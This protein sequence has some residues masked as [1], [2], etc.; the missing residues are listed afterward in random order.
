MQ[1]KRFRAVEFVNREKDIRYFLDY[2][3]NDP[4]RILWVYGF[5]SAGK[6]TLIEYV[7]EQELIRNP[8][9]FKKS[10]YWIKYINF[11]G[12]FVT[13]YDNFLYSF[14][15]EVDE[16]DDFTDRGEVDVEFNLGLIRINSRLFKQIKEKKT[17]LFD[18]LIQ[19]LK[20]IKKKKIII[21]D[22]IQSLQD[23]YLNG[24]RLLLNE[25]LNFCV[26]LT[27]ELHLSH[28]VI[29]TSNTIFLREIYNNSRLKKTSE[30]KLIGDLSQEDI[31]DW[32]TIKGFRKS[33]IDLI[34]EYIGGRAGDVKKLLD[35]V[36]YYNCIED[37]LEEE[38]LKAKSEIKIFFEQSKLSDEAKEKF[39]YVIGEIV[40]AGFF[41]NDSHEGY[42]DIVSAFSD[43]EILFFD[44]VFNKT[45]PSSR[46]YVKAFEK[47][48]G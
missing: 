23:I 39:Y 27:K 30:F 18:E 45:Y 5:K 48:L 21:V 4:E 36:R 38:A 16:E 43:N 28:V 33:E 2:F 15:K 14:L 40:R 37:Y 47:I 29:L 24:E 46:I 22:E 19:N 1:I 6:T 7:I 32:L 20:R 17:N 3:E 34:Y 8:N 26:R 31:V 44:P 9:L 35:S 41:D 25:F 10:P 42:L 11:R 13:S 12:L